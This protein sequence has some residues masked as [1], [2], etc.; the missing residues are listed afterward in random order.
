ML[1]ELLLHLEPLWP[2][3]LPHLLGVFFS[4]FALPRVVDA[5]LLLP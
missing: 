5:F 3:Q 2:W 1:V 4:L